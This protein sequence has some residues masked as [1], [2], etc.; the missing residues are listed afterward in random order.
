MN[1]YGRKIPAQKGTIK[2]SGGY[3]AAGVAT[4]GGMLYT[5]VRLAQQPQDKE[6]IPVSTN[7]MGD[8][9]GTAQ[10]SS[11]P[12]VVP[13]AQQHQPFLASSGLYGNTKV[14]ATNVPSYVLATSGLDN[15]Q[16]LQVAL[17]RRQSWV[18][19]MQCGPVLALWAYASC[20]LADAWLP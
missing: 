13:S 8:T 17:C 18:R 9:S 14:S 4:L 2:L 7:M 3:L 1:K 6:S 12:A 20:V 10:T 11:A 15:E 19:A 5:T 16:K